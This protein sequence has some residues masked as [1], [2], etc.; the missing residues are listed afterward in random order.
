MAN[1]GRIISICPSGQSHTHKDFVNSSRKL[2]EVE[3]ECAE[4]P[5]LNR[6]L[7]VFDVLVDG[8]QLCRYLTIP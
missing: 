6:R 5:S 7:D 1:S 3:D 4:T 2:A 8:R